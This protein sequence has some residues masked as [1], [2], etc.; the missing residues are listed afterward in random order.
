[1]FKYLSVEFEQTVALFGAGHASSA[2][3]GT[4]LEIGGPDV[5]TIE[6]GWAM[7]AVYYEITAGEHV[8][9]VPVH[10]V[11]CAIRLKLPEAKA[12]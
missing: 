7:S 1:M 8:Y 5:E 2:R 10:N 9:V 11:R 6:L 3:V 4:P 12:F